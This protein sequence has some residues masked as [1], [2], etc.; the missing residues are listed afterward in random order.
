MNILKICVLNFQ[1]VK[2]KTR[3]ITKMCRNDT[4]NI[5]RHY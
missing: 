5:F 1:N 2:K 3:K 4:K